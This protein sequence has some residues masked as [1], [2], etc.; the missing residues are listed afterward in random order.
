MGRIE[1]PSIG[2]CIEF[3][4]GAKYVGGRDPSIGAVHTLNISI[5]IC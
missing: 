3:L 4:I 5:Q 1:R 2:F